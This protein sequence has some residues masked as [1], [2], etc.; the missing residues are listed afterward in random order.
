MTE[1]I[2]MLESNNVFLGEIELEDGAFR[3]A[4]LNDRGEAVLGHVLHRWQIYGLPKRPEDVR[5]DEGAEPSLDAYRISRQDAR[6]GSACL[7]WAL[8]HGF[9]AFLLGPSERSC[10]DKL[11]RLP[12]T[13]DERFAILSCIVKGNAEE[14]GR[15]NRALLEAVRLAE[16]EASRLEEE[17]RRLRHES[18]QK[19]V[20]R[21]SGAK[22]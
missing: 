10:W 8:R 20:K 17:I 4:R 14:L 1:T 21:H 22:P 18:A 2:I 16:N 19:L 5:T 13:D 9:H 7:E 15:L 6:F 3:G 11:L 12:L